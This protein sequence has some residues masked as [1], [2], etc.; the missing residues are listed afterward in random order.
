MRNYKLVK[1]CNI[2]EALLSFLTDVVQVHSK[3]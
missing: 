1:V 3:L 2:A